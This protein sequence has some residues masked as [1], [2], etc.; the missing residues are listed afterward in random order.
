MSNSLVFRDYSDIFDNSLG[1]LPVIYIITVDP[2]VMPVV[3]LQR[4]IPAA[5]KDKVLA[6]IKHM[7]AMVVTHKKNS[8]EIRLCID[9]RDL[10]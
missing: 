6:E 8:N 7:T 3:H 2:S 10:N 4:R 1:S 5:M 9:T